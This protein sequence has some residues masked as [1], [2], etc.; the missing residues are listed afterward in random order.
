[1]SFK[2]FILISSFYLR[3]DLLRYCN[4]M[5]SN[6]TKIR[7]RYAD[8]DKM[9]FVYNGKYFEYFEVG[10]TE[11]LRNCGLAYH[12]VEKEGYQLPLTEAFIKYR[13]PAF[14]DDVLIIDAVLNE[15]PK[16]KMRIDYI[17]TKESTGEKITEGYTEH[18]FIKVETKKPVRPPQIF[19][20]AVKPFFNSNEKV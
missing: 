14:Y 4:F 20:D 10:R 7:V 18:V 9:Q 1:M 12:K 8:T 6:K 11:L 19:L 3:K 16:L 15:I 5:L 13:N 2:Q 17:I